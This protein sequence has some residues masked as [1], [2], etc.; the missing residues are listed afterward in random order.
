M[1]TPDAIKAKVFAKSMRG[2]DTAEVDKFLAEVCKELE[3]VYLDNANLK[4]TI[5]R[6]SSKLEY[7]QQMETTMQSTLAVAQETADEVRSNS[8]KQAELVEKET[9]DRCAQSLHAAENEAHRL[10]D[11]ATEKASELYSQI[12]IRVDSLKKA[13]E[14]ECQQM[15]DDA[16]AYAAEL[17]TSAEEETK[18]LKASTEDFCKK[19]SEDTIFESKK[20]LENAREE[21]HQMMMDANSNYRKI[22]ADAE[23]RSNRMIFEAQNKAT[24]ANNDYAN[25]MSKTNSFCKNM[26]YMLRQQ[27]EL[28][29]AFGATGDADADAAENKCGEDAVN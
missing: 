21:V 18:A 29:E 1:L 7:Y 27:V 28:M 4:Q 25:I 22:L 17:R 26:K 9:K 11:E 6:V 2:Y 3:Y 20:I 13:C 12:K 23:E 15:R 19:T 14:M 10:V 24:L 8:M 16:D 5:E